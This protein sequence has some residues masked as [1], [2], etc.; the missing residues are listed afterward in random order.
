[1]GNSKPPPEIWR[2]SNTTPPCRALK[3]KTVVRHMS[4]D[5]E[6]LDNR[7]MKAY[8]R[9]WSIDSR[10]MHRWVR[11]VAPRASFSFLF[12]F[13]PLAASETLARLS[14]RAIYVIFPGRKPDYGYE[15]RKSCV[16]DCGV[17]LDA[18]PELAQPIKLLC[19]GR[20]H[21]KTWGKS[22]EV[23]GAGIFISTTADG[24]M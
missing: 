24:P 2:C 15:L 20:I 23:P 3:D 7:L 10:S 21:R 22:P 4:T 5:A 18:F 17:T 12:N 9:T 13:F 14:R 16:G 8:L 1:M 11:E 19:D 6:L